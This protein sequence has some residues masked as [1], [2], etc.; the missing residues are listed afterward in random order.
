[1][2]PFAIVVL[3]GLLAMGLWLWLIGRHSDSNGLEPFGLRSAREITETRESL[4]AEDLE[5]MLEAQNARRRAR[6]ERE[7]TEGDMERRVMEDVADQTRR[8]AELSSERELDEL[9]EAT[10][11]RRRAKGLPERTRAQARDEF[12]AGSPPGA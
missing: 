9:L 7:L 6:G 4:E 11:A 5:Q 8:R 2:D 10:N 1:M 12:G 3:A